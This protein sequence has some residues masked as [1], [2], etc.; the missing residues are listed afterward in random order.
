MENNRI[1]IFTGHFGSGKTEMAINYAF[2]ATK[3]GCKTILVDIDIVNPFFRSSEVKSILNENNIQLISPNFVNSTLDIPSLPATIQGVF[4]KENTTVIF[5]VGG[6]EDGAKALSRYKQYFDKVKYDMYFVINTRR[7][8]TQTP[9]TIIHLI[10]QVEEQSRLKVNYL[11]SNSNLSYET[12]IDIIE[13]GISIV[14]QVSK[15]TGIPLAYINVP[16]NLEHYSLGQNDD[17]KF[18]VD[19]FMTPGKQNQMFTYP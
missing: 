5:D 12:T 11:V 15:E 8:L 19:L 18:T 16:R 4:D 3:C 14:N 17:K 6:D 1:S 9:E 7:P 10:K 13:E 2:N